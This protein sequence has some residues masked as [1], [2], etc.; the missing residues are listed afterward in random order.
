VLAN[1]LNAV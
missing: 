1:N